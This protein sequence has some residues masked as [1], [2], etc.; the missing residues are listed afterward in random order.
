MTEPLVSVILPTF[1]RPAYLAAAIESVLAQS[2]GRHE[3]LV[4]D[5]GTLDATAGV[6]ARYGERARYLRMPTRGIAHARNAGVAAASGDFLAFLDDD[7]LWLPGKTE[8]Q[9]RAFAERPE[10]DAVYGHMRQF[11]CPDVDPGELERFRHLDGQVLPAPSAPSVLLRRAAWERV[12]PFDTSMQ[13][14][15]EMEWYSRVCLAGLATRTL[16]DVLYL[17]RIHR[18]NTNV[19]FAH[20]QRE[21]LLALKRHLD[22]RRAVASQPT[23]RAS[24]NP[25]TP[26]GETS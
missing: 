1:D 13:V 8:L 5:N 14:A 22:R 11:L 4:V 23:R 9:L 16:D 10:L 19:E 18:T 20:D 25:R 26:D 6:V 24:G 12:G 17:R 3:L 15:V 21:R 7:D 2:V